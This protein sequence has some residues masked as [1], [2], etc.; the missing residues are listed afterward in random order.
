MEWILN[1]VAGLSLVSVPIL[2]VILLCTFDYGSH[3]VLEVIGI[4]T[5][6]CIWIVIS[7]V[8]F[9]AGSLLMNIS[10]T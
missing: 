6:S 5:V 9:W 2:T 8:C 3:W 7:L 4:L 1:K 10:K